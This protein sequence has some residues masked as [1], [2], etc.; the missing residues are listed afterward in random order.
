MCVC[1][2][3]GI[4]TCVLLGMRSE[5]DTRSHRGG[6]TGAWEFLTLILGT[7]FLEKQQALIEPH[8]F[9]FLFLIMEN[10]FQ[11][12]PTCGSLLTWFWP[13]LC[14]WFKEKGRILQGNRCSKM[15][16]NRNSLAHGLQFKM[17]FLNY[18]FN[19]FFLCAHTCVLRPRRLVGVF[20]HGRCSHLLP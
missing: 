8:W 1:L 3:M 17:V 18:Y 15:G 6:V 10:L 13:E 7:E 19:F 2:R 16:L 9:Y 11:K 20:Y 4:C 14:Q 12:L 5:E